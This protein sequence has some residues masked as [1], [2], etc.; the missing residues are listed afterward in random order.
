MRSITAERFGEGVQ[1]GAGT[2]L[3]IYAR[4]RLNLSPGDLAQQLW[5]DAHAVSEP[6][7]ALPFELSQSDE[8]HERTQ[9]FGDPCRLRSKLP[10]FNEF[11]KAL[12]M[13]GERV[14][15][16]AAERDMLEL[17]RLSAG[18][19]AGSDAN[20]F[21]NPT[22]NAQR[23]FKRNITARC[24]RLSNGKGVRRLGAVLGRK[25]IKSAPDADELLGFERS[26][27]LAVASSGRPPDGSLQ[28][29]LGEHTLYKTLF[30]QC[31]SQ[32][33]HSYIIPYTCKKYKF[34]EF[35]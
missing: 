9:G 12:F 1:E 23:R 28:L 10:A 18:D 26:I 19:D 34:M 32:R 29:T 30:N 25:D 2:L 8:I 22:V 21:R 7:E 6:S 27:N 20:A 14:E 5:V 11:E 24:E 33:L 15:S 4:Q 3:L 17:R 16:V 35:L 13:Q 31:F